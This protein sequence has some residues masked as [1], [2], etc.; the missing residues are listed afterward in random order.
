MVL[1]IS[2]SQLQG[3]WFK[4][5]GQS[6][7]SSLALSMSVWVSS[8]FSGLLIPPKNMPI[9]LL[10]NEWYVMDCRPIEGVIPHRAW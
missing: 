6:Q 8:R 1:W 2:T 10:V 4:V 5:Q 3:H 9:D 7:V